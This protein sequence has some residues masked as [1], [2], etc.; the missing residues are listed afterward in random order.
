MM[1]GIDPRSSDCEYPLAPVEIAKASPFV[2]QIANF[3][4]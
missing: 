3:S 4:S 1:V 2:Q